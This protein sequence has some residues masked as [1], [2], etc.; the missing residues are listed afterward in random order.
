M[1]P[2]AHQLRWGYSTV[3]DFEWRRDPTDPKSDTRPIQVL[4]ATA[5][6]KPDEELTY[7]NAVAALQWRGTLEVFNRAD[8]LCQSPCSVERRLGADIL[9]QLGCP[10]RSFPK[11]CTQVLLKILER[12]ENKKVLCAI[13]VALSHHQAPEAVGPVSRFR[14]HADDEVRFGVVMALTGYEDQEAHVVLIELTSDAEAE[15]RDWATFALGTQSETDTPAIRD[16]LAAR[17][18]DTDVDTRC[19]ALVGLA[20]RRDQRAVPSLHRELSGE[21]VSPLA[22]EA[23]TLIAI[24]QL[25]KELIALRARWDGDTSLLE[26]AIQAC[27]LDPRLAASRTCDKVG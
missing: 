1:R 21:S 12:E 16:A 11:E 13:L 5:L 17:L 15:V 10:D 4:I 9:G 18:T 8:R 14:H 7:W 25:I 23:A 26:Q 20:R 3:S 6:S 22:I 2:S 19:E 27:L 24:P